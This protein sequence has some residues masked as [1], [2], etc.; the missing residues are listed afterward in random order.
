MPT[1][2]Q[3]GEEIIGLISERKSI[4]SAHIEALIYSQH[5][6][7]MIAD[8]PMMIRAATNS[9]VVRE[10]LRSITPDAASAE[11]LGERNGIGHR[12][13]WNS[14][15]S[16][17]SA[18]GLDKLVTAI[19]T[20]NDTGIGTDEWVKVAQGSFMGKTAI[21]YHLSDLLKGAEPNIGEPYTCYVRDTDKP[22][23][24]QPH[25]EE[26]LITYDQFMRDDR[27]LMIFGSQE[28]R[29]RFAESFW[30]SG[31]KGSYGNY[32]METDHKITG[33]PITFGRGLSGVGA[34][35]PVDRS[36]IYLALHESTLDQVATVSENPMFNF[37]IRTGS[38]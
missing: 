31:K 35:S 6:N 36:G 18:H 12:E 38:G 3:R 11:Y 15:G 2:I 4:V 1:F 33:R 22:V 25:N 30:T 14:V 32:H 19:R 10:A 17:C 28:N 26:E 27:I 23:I 16:L 24:H 21:R 13:I 8:A 5:H 9:S 20:G 37:G 29:T 34:G 7:L